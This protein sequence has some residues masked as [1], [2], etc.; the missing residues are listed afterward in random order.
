MQHSELVTRWDSQDPETKK[1]AYLA[2]KR[3]LKE[4]WSAVPVEKA[5]KWNA[6][7]WPTEFLRTACYAAEVSKERVRQRS[8]LTPPLSGS[9]SCSLK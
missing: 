8:R 2:V 1:A 5:A 9:H 3:Y 6:L 4:H 7:S